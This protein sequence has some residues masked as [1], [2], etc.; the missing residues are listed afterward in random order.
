VEKINDKTKMLVFRRIAMS[1]DNYWKPTARQEEFLKTV[2][3]MSVDCLMGKGT[4]NCE[5]YIANLRVMADM[6][7][8]ENKE[9]NNEKR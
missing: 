6:L 2:M 3:G 7:E 8:H 4:N 1:N 5:A 9:I